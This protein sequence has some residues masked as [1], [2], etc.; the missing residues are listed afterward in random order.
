MALQAALAVPAVQRGVDGDAAAVE[1]AALDDARELVADHERVPELRVPDAGLLVPVQV[2]AA[3]AHGRDAHQAL[4]VADR[5]HGLPG[6]A[7]IAGAVQ[8]GDGVQAAVPWASS[9]RV[10]TI[11][12]RHEL[13]S[14]IEVPAACRRWTACYR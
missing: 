13:Q 8:A 6:D 2:R 11:L 5:G 3:D 9:N 7:H 1:R 4:T 10:I 12:V 14:A